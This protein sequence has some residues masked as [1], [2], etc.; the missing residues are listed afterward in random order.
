MKL[1]LNI[2]TRHNYV[3]LIY[4]SRFGKSGKK[5]FKFCRTHNFLQRFLG[6]SKNSTLVFLCRV[7]DCH[8]VE[9]EI[10]KIFKI[11]LQQTKHGRE[12]FMGDGKTM[13]DYMTQIINHMGQ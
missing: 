8:H 2:A 9:D 1:N 5:I 3:Y 10:Y 7:K 13:I 6:Y 11:H 12:Y 4:L